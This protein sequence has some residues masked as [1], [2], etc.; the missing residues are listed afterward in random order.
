MI[1]SFALKAA[2]SLS[3]SSVALMT[4]VP[5]LVAAHETHTTAGRVE[6]HCFLIVGQKENRTKLRLEP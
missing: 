3:L 5:P 1:K 4:I 6:S 2:V